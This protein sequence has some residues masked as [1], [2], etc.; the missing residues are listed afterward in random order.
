MSSRGNDK[1]LLGSYSGKGVGHDPMGE[2]LGMKVAFRVSHGEGLKRP[3]VALED[4]IS[5]E[6]KIIDVSNLELSIDPNTRAC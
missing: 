1:G 2:E 3:C 4:V 5:V 6:E